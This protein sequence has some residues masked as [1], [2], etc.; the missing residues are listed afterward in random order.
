MEK[1]Y[2]HSAASISPVGF[3]SGEM[4]D[5][6]APADFRVKEPEYKSVIP[7]LQLRRMSKITRM[8]MMCAKTVS[9][10]AKS[11]IDAIIVASGLGNLADT[12]RF[13]ELIHGQ[14]QGLLSPTAF[15]QSS[16]NTLSGQIALDFKNH[17]YNMT[18]VQGFLSFEQALRDAVEQFGFGAKEILLGAADEHIPLLDQLAGENGFSADQIG[19]FGEGAAF[20]KLGKKPVSGV[21]VQDVAVK[22]W[23]ANLEEELRA[24]AEKNGCNS[25]LHV[26]SFSDQ[27]FSFA[28]TQE[29]VSQLVGNYM[30]R[31]AFA[32]NLGY[33]Y[34][35][36][37]KYSRVLI[38]N[39]AEEGS[40]GLILLGYDEV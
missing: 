17:S 38:V 6:N 15:T 25:N 30:T 29:N 21:F 11:E 10:D 35:K 31:S 13:M 33:S 26:I 34:L 16:H 23:A 7:V 20:F 40:L 12:Y 22:I 9:G 39:E 1:L 2:I 4:A 28:K 32:M 14:E 19:Q 18:H 37:G 5:A 3:C 36:E 27:S 8:A 24:F